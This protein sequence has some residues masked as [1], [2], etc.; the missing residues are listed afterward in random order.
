VFDL[1]WKDASKPAGN[2]VQHFF[3]R[4]RATDNLLKLWHI[5]PLITEM[6]DGREENEDGFQ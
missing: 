4:V 1:Q 3:L 5:N 2:W 6:L